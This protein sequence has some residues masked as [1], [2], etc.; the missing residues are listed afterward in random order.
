MFE[1]PPA[2]GADAMIPPRE[3]AVKFPCPQCGDNLLALREMPRLRPPLPSGHEMRLLRTLEGEPDL[4]K[5][6]FL[7]DISL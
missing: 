1:C 5:V 6:M 3:G 7:S 4:A 2:T